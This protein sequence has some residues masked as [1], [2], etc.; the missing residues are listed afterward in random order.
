MCSDRRPGQERRWALS[1]S[2]PEP[3]S[4]SRKKAAIEKRTRKAIV[5]LLASLALLLLIL[6]R[7]IPRQMPQGWRIIRPPFEVSALAEQGKT[8][9]AGGLE[10]LWAIDRTLAKEPEA[11][12]TESQTGYIHAMLAEREGSLWIGHEKGVT[13]RGRGREVI[14]TEK[15]GLPAKRT[16]CLLRDLQG[17]IWAGTD[18]GAAVFD[19]TGRWSALTK[20]GGLLDNNVNVMREDP[21]GGLW[22]G[23]YVSPW[24][25]VSL[26]KSDGSW[27][28]FSAGNGLQH[29]NITSILDDGTGALW[30]GTGFLDQ[31]GACRVV[32]EGEQ[33]IIKEKLSKKDGLAGAKVRSLF[34]DDRGQIWYA[35]ESD[36]IAIRLKD[37]FRIIRKRDGLSDDEVKAFL[38]D[39]DGNLWLGTRDGITY[40]SRDAVKSLVDGR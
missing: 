36:G 28:Y 31:G 32:K 21:S 26:R 27:Q 15:D 39:S 37:R 4:G 20:A 11:V 16:H 12:A 5:Y 14:Y 8:I 10:G 33:W 19:G 7:L 34:R 35:S 17:R 2:A 6:I 38:R 24:G 9:W 25:G 23:S 29:N 40:I 30:I 18:R 13:F 1:I 22:F 3:A